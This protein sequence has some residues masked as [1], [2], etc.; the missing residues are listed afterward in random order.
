[1]RNT[2]KRLMECLKALRSQMQVNWV[3]TKTNGSL[4]RQVEHDLICGA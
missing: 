4:Q 2:R 1:M 3:L